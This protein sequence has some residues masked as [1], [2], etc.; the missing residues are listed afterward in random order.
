MNMRIYRAPFSQNADMFKG[1]TQ[2]H[3]PIEKQYAL[4]K[5]CRVVCIRVLCTHRMVKMALGVRFTEFISL[6]N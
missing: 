2:P 6:A 1:N 5:I 3:T 4:S